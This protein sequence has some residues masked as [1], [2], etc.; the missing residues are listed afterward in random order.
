MCP[1]AAPNTG[2]QIDPD[3]PWFAQQID[4]GA[5]IGKALDVHITPFGVCFND[6]TFIMGFIFNIGYREFC[7]GIV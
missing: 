3:I 6:L 5:L 4:P 1:P 2:P 7:Y